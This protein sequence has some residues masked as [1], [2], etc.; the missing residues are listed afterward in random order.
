MS[1]G[2]GIDTEKE[3]EELIKGGKGEIDKEK[4]EEELINKRRKRN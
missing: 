2:R 1:G 4:E 3:E